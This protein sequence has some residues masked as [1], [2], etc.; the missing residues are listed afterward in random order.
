MPKKTGLPFALGNPTRRAICRAVAAA[1]P[2]SPRELSDQLGIE[3]TNLAYHVRVLAAN[4][5]LRLVDEKPT[6]GSLKHIYEFTVTEPWALA[7]LGLDGDED[8]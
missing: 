8:R 2:I 7:E 1:G 4:G 5:A 3:T 6:R